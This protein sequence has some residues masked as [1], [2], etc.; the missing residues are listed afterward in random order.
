[1]EA[2]ICDSDSWG[3]LDA[4]CLGC[5]RASLRIVPACSVAS[6]TGRGGLVPGSG[7]GQQFGDLGRTSS[8]SAL[9][10]VSN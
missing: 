5:G 3:N 4:Q 8:A 10:E 2:A 1:M 7:I 6:A 9:A